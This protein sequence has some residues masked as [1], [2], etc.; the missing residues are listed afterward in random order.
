MTRDVG[1]A[2]IFARFEH[3]N[4][5]A[6]E[7]IGGKMGTRRSLL[8]QPDCGR[9][10]IEIGRAGGARRMQ[11]ELTKSGDRWNARDLL[12]RSG[13]RLGRLPDQ[14]RLLLSQRAPGDLNR[15]FIR[16]G[17]GIRLADLIGVRFTGTNAVLSAAVV[18]R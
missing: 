7:A 3:A 12:Q 2:T 18:F 4:T 10:Q 13:S 1:P 15:H 5:L 11:Q 6:Y 8:D 16:A 14:L 17:A 9:Q